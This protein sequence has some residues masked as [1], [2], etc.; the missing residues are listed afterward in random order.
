MR[1]GDKKPA[2]GTSAAGNTAKG[3]CNKTK[4]PFRKYDK[5][6]SKINL[7]GGADDNRS[8]FGDDP[9]IA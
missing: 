6:K 7:T 9:N 8:R 4:P 5:Y 2:G 1:G 3:Q